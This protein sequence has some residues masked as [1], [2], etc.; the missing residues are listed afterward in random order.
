LCLGFLYQVTARLSRI[1]IAE[2]SAMRNNGKAGKHSLAEAVF[3]R[4]FSF[5]MADFYVK[6]FTRHGDCAIFNQGENRA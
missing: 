5:F 3:R 6:G 1:F 4:V 2:I